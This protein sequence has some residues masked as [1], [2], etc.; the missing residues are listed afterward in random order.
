MKPL[1]KIRKAKEIME[2]L[3]EGPDGG[4]GYIRMPGWMGSV[5]WSYGGGWDHV[6]VSPANKD[7][8]PTWDDMCRIKEIFFYD[9]EAVV[10]YHPAKSNYVNL[11]PNCLHL[12]RPQKV[13][14]PVPPTVYV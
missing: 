11:M 3:Q 4:M 9:S 7:I 6:S 8:M 5:I 1:S 2:I 10:Q 14:M 12:W 13:D